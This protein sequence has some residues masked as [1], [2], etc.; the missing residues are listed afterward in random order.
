V[1]AGAA[2]IAVPSSTS[3][4]DMLAPMPVPARSRAV[5]P[6]ASNEACEGCHDEIAREWRGS[7]HRRAY[8][9]PAFQAA[10]AREPLPFCRGCHAPEAH[11]AEPPA[12]ALAELGVACVT[13]HV[14]GGPPLAAPRAIRAE[15]APHP[16]LR[17]ARFASPAA[18]AGCHEFSFPDSARRRA[19]E[20]MQLTVSEHAA[21]PHAGVACATCHMPVVGSGASAHRSHAFAAS[22]DAGAQR[23]AVRVTAERP[24]TATARVRLAAPDVGH[25]FPTGDLFRRLV[26]RAEVEGPDHAVIASARRY[27]ARHFAEA[28]QPLGAHAREARADDR[29]G[30]PARRGEPV[31]VD[32]DLGAEA[33]RRPITYQVVYQRVSAW[34][35]GRDDDALVESEV[36]LHQGSLPPDPP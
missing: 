34:R 16:V 19:A 31:I 15:G 1:I 32:L 29:P 4:G 2:S 5:D 28:P 8:V 10:L 14:V 20:P 22:R 6:A 17:D 36:V 3:R 21:S 30:A 12:P 27:L 33:A 24:D 9:D 35:D 18:C 23:R 25:A 26:V 13:C 7:M 11:P